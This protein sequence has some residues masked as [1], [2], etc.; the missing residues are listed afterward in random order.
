MQ[1]KIIIDRL[2]KS[3]LFLNLFSVGG[4][5]VI[6]K[7]LSLIT[8]GYPARILSPE[9]Y[10]LVAFGSSV[11]AYAGIVL[12]PG[13][14]VWGTRHIARDRINVGETLVIV[15]LARL[16]LA[17]IAYAALAAYAIFFLKSPLERSVVLICGL[18]VF[19]SAIMVDWVFNGL[20]LMR[21]PAW[22]SV[23]V[24][25]VNVI[26]L[27]SFIHTPDDVLLYALFSPVMGL[28]TVIISY[29]LVFRRNVRFVI[30]CFALFKQSLRESIPLGITMS[31]I[32]VLHY[33]NNLIVKSYLG[34][35]ALGVFMAAFSLFEHASTLPNILGTVFMSR[36]SRCV[37]SSRESAIKDA[38]IYAQLHMLAAFFVAAFM[39]I[40]APAIIR[41][42][43]GVKYSGSAELLRYMAVGVIFNYAICGYT[44]CMISFGYDRVMFLVVLVSVIVSVVGGLLLVPRIGATGAAIVIASIDLAGWLVSLPYYKRAIGS[45]HLQAWIRPA[46]GGMAIV[47]ASFL[48]QKTTLLL[49]LRIFLCMMFYFIFVAG[50]IRS[51]YRQHLA[52][53]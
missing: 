46:L 42:I 10:G 13:I 4:A 40:E 27:F 21:I 45:L 31:L 50:Q 15:N 34:A 35:A 36:L 12:L 38:A 43:Y 28:L 2:F 24:S 29:Y 37:V 49:W 3:S 53:T 6:T 23:A 18:S 8:L 11:T 7:L 9:G 33:A 41:I 25:V 32:I 19:N 22:I 26:A 30:P 17:F 20:E 16:F 44:S 39:F 5:S 14:M 48:L 52:L 47:V 1:V 51:S